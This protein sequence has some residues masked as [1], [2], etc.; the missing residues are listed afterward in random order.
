MLNYE[1]KQIKISE[2]RKLYDIVVSK[3]HL[4]R[5]LK[6]NI[7]FSFVNYMLKETYC[8][9]YG[10][11]ATEPEVMFKLL[12]L[13]ELYDLSDEQLV[14]RAMTDM[15]FK[16]FLD[17][18]PEDE[19]VCSSLLTIFRK[20][21]L[22]NEE[23][24]NNMLAETVKQAVEKGIIKSNAIII[25][26]THSKSKGIQE[27]PTQ[28]LRRTTKELRKQIYKS[29][30]ELSK[31][32]PDKPEPTDT[33]DKEI[34]YTQNLINAIE[35]D[36]NSSNNIKIQK[37]FNKVKNLLKDDKIKKIQSIAD[38]DART[39]YKGYN[40][41]FFGYKNHIA[42]TEDRIITALEVSSG[43]AHDGQYLKSL[44]EKTKKQGIEVKE[45]L[46]D[47][48]Y[49]GRDNLEYCKENNI[50][51]ISRLNG[52]IS[53][54]QEN[55]EDGFEYIKDADTL[56]CPAGHLA[57]SKYIKKGW[58]AKGG[59][60]H[61]GKFKFYFDTDICKNCPHK[62]GCYKDGNKTKSYTITLLSDIHKEQS[63]FE[64][65]EYFINRIKQRYMIEAKNSELKHSH[66]LDTSKYMG[67][68]GMKIQSYLTSIVANVKRII[69][70]QEI[71]QG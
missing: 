64:K 61:N 36:V 32:F 6:E 39:G 9:Y 25:D 8:E 3:D 35:I 20:N 29:K 16:Y 55:K 44:V 58:M 49:S 60:Y 30:P 38:Q 12:F 70:L 65:T 22:S 24:L 63:D 19:I 15:A 62:D 59:H 13:K 34:E 37:E 53:N 4:L 2:Y 51:V 45:I 57:K 21:R 5:K 11:P 28:M 7:D 27:T 41:R 40:N 66:G 46:G 10:R 31:K 17:L 18:D 48:A 47:K 23:T 71:M 33:L 69:K 67:I 43:E 42:M 50:T 1:A 52:I 14:S 68:C 26:S 56:R 54:A